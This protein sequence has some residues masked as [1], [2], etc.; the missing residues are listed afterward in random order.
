MS[1]ILLVEDEPNQWLLYQMDLED[2]GYK[3]V[4]A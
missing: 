4:T 3:V 2:D 1:R